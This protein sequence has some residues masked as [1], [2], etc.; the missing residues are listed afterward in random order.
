MK[1][2]VGIDVSSEKLDVC[3]LDSS[4]TTLKEVTLPNNINGASSI[5]E[6]VLQFHQ[7]FNY[8]KIVIGMESTSIYSFHPATFLSEDLEL[9]SL[10]LVE[11][12]I[13]NPKSIHRYKGLFE[14]DKN[15][16]IDAFR[17]A[18]FL[19]IERFN[20]TV[21]KEERYVALQRLTRSRYQ[22]VHQLTEC[23][24]H[25]LE[26][27]YYKCNTLSKELDTSV[28]GATMLDLL[29][30]ALTLDEM[31]E[32]ELEDLANL[33][34]EKG[35]GRFSDPQ[36]LAKTIKKAIRDSYR[37]G[38]VVQESVDMVLATYARL[39][40]T[41]KKQIKDLEKSI[42][43][44][45]E[46]VTEAQCLKSI[47]GI[48]IV[49]AAGIV[50]EIG[51]I[52]RFEN[53]AQLAKYCGLYWKKNLPLTLK[54]Q[55][56]KVPDSVLQASKNKDGKF[57][58]FTFASVSDAVFG[59]GMFAISSIV[60]GYNEGLLTNPLFY[61]GFIVA[62]LAF[63]VTAVFVIYLLFILVLYF[64]PALRKR[65]VMTIVA[66]ALLIVFNPFFC[67]SRYSA[68]FHNCV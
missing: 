20:K 31:A 7:S 5:K 11:V 12:V 27:L 2:F 36:K 10:G 1:L 35:R 13:Q 56:E 37:L 22:M 53:E 25:F 61:L 16:R 32:M 51:Q 62:A 68:H 64:V 43:A 14:E 42:V 57:E 59:V 3:F 33:L 45:F 34:Q 40:Q 50:A 65:K 54:A 19:R 8:E 44:L 46:I 24:Q 47:P 6:D 38:K 48:G 4:D 29:S 66:T 39:I 67:F 18:D 30:D 9:K 28:F 21:L 49:Y 60:Y 23:K 15:D 52:E 63:S 55:V 26:N 58:Y 41:L 17:I